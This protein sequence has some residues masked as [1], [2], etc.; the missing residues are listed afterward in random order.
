MNTRRIFG[1]RERAAGGISARRER[2]G[3]SR[4]PQVITTMKDQVTE[5]TMKDEGLGPFFL[6][7][8]LSFAYVEGLHCA[9]SALLREKMDSGSIG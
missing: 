1:L 8:A 9:R 4:I 7:A 3:L 6:S 2:C 5:S